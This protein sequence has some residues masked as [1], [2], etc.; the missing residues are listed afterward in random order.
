[1]SK[2]IIPQQKPWINPIL[3]ILTSLC[4]FASTSVFGAE[5]MQL[6]LLTESE[7]LGEVPTIITASR[8]PQLQS[9]A[10]AAVTV[11]DA[12]TIRATGV[13][14]LV[15]LMQL[16]PGFQIG[17]YDSSQPVVTYHGLADQFPRHMQVLVDGRSIYS[18]MFRGAFWLD[19]T[20]AIEDIERIEVIRG[21]NTVTYGSNAFFGVINIITLHASQQ[22]GT[23]I[24]VIAGTNGMR[25]GTVRHAWQVG[26]HNFRITGA[27]QEDNGFET[28]DDDVQVGF[29]DFT[30]DLRL[31]AADTLEVD[32]GINENTGG[33]VRRRQSFSERSVS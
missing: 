4:A 7:Y 19:L 9:E 1:M 12:E 2:Q 13:R 21:P 27:W 17:F 6:S 8:M 26:E 10:P 3:V 30:G 29:L 11:I 25:D 24:K 32:L 16:V 15:E 20:I 33:E 31:G 14:N 18:P 23:F 5:D 28:R 22:T